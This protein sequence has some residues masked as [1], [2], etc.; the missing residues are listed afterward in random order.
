MG[1]IFPLAK[2]LGRSGWLAFARDRR[3]N[4]AV[5]FALSA[6]AL[7]L[8][9][10]LGLD[11]LNAYS[12]KA[13]LNAAADAAAIAA[14]AT[15][16]TY[17]AAN[18]GSQTGTALSTAA[19]AAGQAQGLKAFKANVGSANLVGSVTPTITM[20]YASL[21]FTSS[22]TWSGAV[23]TNFGGLVNVSQFAIAGAASATSALPRYQDFY[24]VTDVSG[25]MGIPAD[26][27][28]QALL[29]ASNPDNPA[30]AQQ[31]YYAGCQFACHFSGFQGFAYTRSAGIPLKLDSVG[32][33][34]QSLLSTATATK[35]IA[36]QFRVG[37]YPFIVHAIQAAAL[38]SDF[39]AANAV[40][41]NLANYLD[42]GTSNQGMGSGGT[43]FENLGNDMAKFLQAPGT[44]ASAA[45]PQPFIV[46][47][48]DGV[49]NNQTYSPWTGSQPQLP[50]LSVC[51]NAK[52]LGY[53]VAV[54]LITY[55]P[56]NNPVPGF[57]NNEDITVNDMLA[58]NSVTTNIQTCAS[59]GYFYQASSSAAINSAMQAI[60][61][62]ATQSTRLTK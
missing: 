33:A 49:D 16:K 12:N 44:G 6:P 43:H 40:A 27:A 7:V 45:S 38:S 29:Q 50:N 53:T 20:S 18:S 11:F 25:S 2:R 23:A 48:T 55:A 30:E 31:G 8:M 61:A 22:V 35:V 41:G 39:T 15:A 47:V 37:I 3:G 56:I 57:A 1:S 5:A 9:M 52:A 32:T 17:F 19:I 46:L 4:F 21:V 24:I 10:G 28:N 62:Q 42:Q 36:N 54:L 59:A 58:N 14:V 26:Q 34:L 13:R 51:A 60:F